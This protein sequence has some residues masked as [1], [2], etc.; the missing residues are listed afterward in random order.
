MKDSKENV[1]NRDAD[2]FPSVKSVFD[3][4]KTI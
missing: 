3:P 1:H 2:D 4:E